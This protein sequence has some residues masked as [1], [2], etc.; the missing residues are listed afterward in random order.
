MEKK[1]LSNLFKEWTESMTVH[2][3]PNIL[4]TK[5][6]TIRIIWIISFLLSVS[7][8]LYIITLNLINYFNFDVITKIRIVE[9]D[10]VKFP[11]VTICNIN[12]FFTQESIEFVKSILEINNITE[13][14]N[15]DFDPAFQDQ[16][17]K[18]YFNNNIF[19]YMSTITSKSITNENKEKFFVPFN[20][21]FISC[22]YKFR[23]CNESDWTWFY[24]SL[25]GN[26]YRFNSVQSEIKN[27]NQ[28]GKFNGLMIEM[29][30]GIPEKIETLS[31]ST[32]AHVYINDNSVKPII[33][34]GIDIAP[35]YSTNLVLERIKKKVM[36]KPYSNCI[37]N[38]DSIDS[39]DS[40]Y[41]RKVFRS[42]LTY[43]QNDCYHAYL[44]SEI[45]KN[46]GCYDITF[47]I[48]PENKNSCD[49]FTEI[50]CAYSIYQKLTISNFKSKIQS[51]CP[52]ECESIS[53]G[54]TKAASRYPSVSY[55]KDMVK[56][57]RVKS[58][59]NNRTNISIEELREN[60]LSLNIYYE[61]LRQTEIT[62]NKSISWDGLVASI[63]GTFG[64]FLGISFLS[65]IELIDLF[66]QIMIF[67][68]KKNESNK[69]ILMK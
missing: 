3:F 44:Q 32:G 53:F 39:F 37:D 62:E 16:Y 17:S 4:R 69:V 19:R 22:I 57:E 54:I 65:F 8:C 48:L 23:P 49:N 5:F 52:L 66:L 21:M 9:K 41:Y 50:T 1:K 45:Y 64:L 47:N 6:L 13:M 12:P 34:E 35:G 59:F 60:V 18:L 10:S 11:A 55:G 36:P 42:N 51:L 29:F 30:V 56:T 61:Y 15:A 43:S 67:L 63:G 26:C 58:L 25:Y 68:F 33:E 38:L 31:I 27:S 40:E 7:G 46:C 28:G 2:G 24:D 14:S 20:K